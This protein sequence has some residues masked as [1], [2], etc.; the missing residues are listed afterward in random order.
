MM[1]IVLDGDVDEALKDPK[2][3]STKRV[4]KARKDFVEL[5]FRLLVM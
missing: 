3:P 1:D 2:K 4:D 5:L